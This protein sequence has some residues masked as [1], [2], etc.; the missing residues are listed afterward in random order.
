MSMT[1]KRRA[2]K[3]AAD[4]GLDSVQR[5]ELARLLRAT[6]RK[7]L[8]KARSEVADLREDAEADVREY[9]REDN[10]NGAEGRSYAVA[11]LDDALEAIRTLL[12]AAAKGGES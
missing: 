12:P 3:F 10:R 2:T 8:E 5:D 9:E 6:E 7:T 1:A 11:A 4:W